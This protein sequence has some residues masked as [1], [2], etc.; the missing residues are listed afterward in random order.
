LSD[1]IDGRF[2]AARNL[3]KTFPPDV[4]AVRDVSLS[5]GKG[6]IFAFLGPNGAGKTTT[7]RMVCG[8]CRPTG[9]TVSLEGLGPHRARGAYMRRIALVSQH[10]NVDDDL[11][12]Y[13]NMLVHAALYDLRSPRSRIMELLE[14]AELA[15]L[16]DRVALS[17]SGGMKR[18]LQIVRS[19][20]HEPAM[21]FLDEPTVGLDPMSRERI[22]DL[23]HRLN[24]KGMTVF[25]T[26]HYIDEAER[27]AGRV[28]IIHRGRIIETDSPAALIERLGPWCRETYADGT[29]RREHFATKEAAESWAAGPT[30]GPASGADGFQRL[31]I[32]RSSLEDVF[33]R[34]TGDSLSGTRSGR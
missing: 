26:T 20:V 22:W 3:R 16:A 23:I 31:V 7:L 1:T 33:I 18:R 10:F 29:T 19:L 24:E 30:S 25:F 9:G 4:E 15:D 28:S 12:V 6:E 5:I 8:L 32:R 27:Y 13:E 14:V 2:F 21:L 11:T 17:L 34:L